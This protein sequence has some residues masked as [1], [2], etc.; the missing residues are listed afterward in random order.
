MGDK[1]GTLEAGKL[2][3]VIV[4]DGRPD[5]VLDDLARVVHV[6]KDGRQWVADGQV[7]LPRHPSAPLA[8]PSPPADT[9]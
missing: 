1:L 5:E 2:A 9:K 6:F 7:R 8:K 3:D 4:V